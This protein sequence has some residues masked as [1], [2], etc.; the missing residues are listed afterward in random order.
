MTDLECDSHGFVKLGL[1]FRPEEVS[2]RRFR[3]VGADRRAI[4]ERIA[5]TI[6]VLTVMELGKK[7]GRLQMINQGMRI[8]FFREIFLYSFFF[9]IIKIKWINKKM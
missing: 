1:G 2:M 3:R 5:A 7:L 4:G 9:L 8:L 6:A